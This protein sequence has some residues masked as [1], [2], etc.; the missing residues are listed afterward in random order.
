MGY[1]EEA[2]MRERHT[3]SDLDQAAFQAEARDL[4]RRLHKLRSDRWYKIY[5]NRNPRSW[6]ARYLVALEDIETL[7]VQ[8]A[9]ICERL[10]HWQGILMVDD[11][12]IRSPVRMWDSWNKLRH[13][14]ECEQTALQDLES[15]LG[16]GAG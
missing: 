12:T 3:V 11:H 2:R 14:A 16:G 13:A 5:K 8:L 4:R 9:P 6:D 7:Q 10:D 1:L 15:D